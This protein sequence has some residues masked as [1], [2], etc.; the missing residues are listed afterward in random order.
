MQDNDL[1][2]TTDEIE[3]LKMLEEKKQILQTEINILQERMDKNYMFLKMARIEALKMCNEIDDF[4]IISIEQKYNEL[5]K[6]SNWNEM[7]YLQCSNKQ[8]DLKNALMF[9]IIPE[10]E[11]I[12]KI[13]DKQEPNQSKKTRKSKKGK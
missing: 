8:I 6:K 4:N 3:N 2:L 11:F 12:L 10:I 9:W 1:T 7:E 5:L 13:N